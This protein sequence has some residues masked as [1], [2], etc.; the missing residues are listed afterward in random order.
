MFL[1]SNAY[2]FC[3][4]MSIPWR[5]AQ[6]TAD[7]FRP[8]RLAI[9]TAGTPESLLANWLNSRRAGKPCGVCSQDKTVYLP[10]P[11]MQRDAANNLCK[12]RSQGNRSACCAS[13]SSDRASIWSTTSVSPR[14]RSTPLKPMQVL[15]RPVSFCMTLSISWVS[16]FNSRPDGNSLYLRVACANEPCQTFE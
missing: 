13:V 14:L 7:E 6:L 11:E 10:L 3:W 1:F 15:S 12:V 9:S 4:A 8:G 2:S 5:A 16:W